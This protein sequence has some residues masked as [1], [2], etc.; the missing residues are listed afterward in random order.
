MLTG[1][2]DD[3][4]V[5][6]EEIF[7]PILP[8]MTYD[9]IREA[10]AYVNARPRPL[11]T[12]YFGEDPTRIGTRHRSHVVGDHGHQ[13]RRRPGIAGGTPLRGDRAERHGV[14]QGSRRLQEFQSRETGLS[15]DARRR[16][17]ATDEAAL[18]GGRGRASLQPAQRGRKSRRLID[19]TPRTRLRSN[20]FSAAARP[21]RV[22]PE[23]SPEHTGRVA[24]EARHVGNRHHVPIHAASGDHCPPDVLE[25]M[26]VHVF[27]DDD[28]DLVVLEMRAHRG[29]DDLPGVALVLGLDAHDGL[30]RRRAATRVEDARKRGGEV[31]EGAAG[32][33]DL[34]CAQVLRVAAQQSIEQRARR[35]VTFSTSKTWFGPCST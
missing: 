5:M 29:E 16:R 33:R 3:M 34:Q 28:D 32:K 2:T 9:D 4:T 1:V 19:S 17:P 23:A 13:R 8:V 26:D 35:Q 18:Y 30:H 14:L 11:A 6:T 31:P 24:M 25:V 20:S 7:A 22:D 27:V 10:V 21:G 12:Y 15:P